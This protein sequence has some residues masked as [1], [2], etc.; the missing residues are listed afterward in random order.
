MEAAELGGRYTPPA[1]LDSCHTTTGSRSIYTDN[2]DALTHHPVPDSLE[3]TVT[4]YQRDDTG[5]VAP[6]EVT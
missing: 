3:A 6:Q 5:L 1:A 4:I 2:A